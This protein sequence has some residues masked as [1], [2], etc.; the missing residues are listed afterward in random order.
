ME[1]GSRM[2][3]GK[4]LE[5]GAGNGTGE[6]AGGIKEVLRGLFKNKRAFGA[7]L[8]LGAG[9]VLA[10]GLWLAAGSPKEGDSWADEGTAG[11]N[12]TVNENVIYKEETA[13][14]PLPVGADEEELLSG[15]Y[16]AMADGSL[17]EAAE[18]LNSNEEMFK[19]LV[20]ETLGGD[21]Y[22]YYE[23]ASGVTGTENGPGAAAATGAEN[24]S[25]TAGAA[26][27]ENDSGTAGVTGA[28]NGSGAAAVT[29][30][31]NASG[32]ENRPVRKMEKLSE[33]GRS[34]GLVV[35]RYNTIFFG[36]FLNGVPEGQCIA[37]QAM[38]LNEPRYTYAAGI[39]S[40]GKMNGKGMTGFYYYADIPESGFVRTEK[41]GTYIDN[42]LDGAFTYRTENRDGEYLHWDMEADA[43]TTVLSDNW[44]YYD[45]RD[46]YML[47]SSED[48]A[49]AYVLKKDQTGAVLWNNLILWD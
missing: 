23:E 39:W 14:E 4:D 36:S 1:A 30:A 12:R 21:K 26:G 20:S 29:G 38:V 48:P 7:V 17:T 35:T 49:R 31:E 28:E 10:G 34:E 13:P 16:H 8:A 37:V 43:G 18:I 22:C 41:V 24:D 32:P 44:K 9:C 5:K 27:A 40:G 46:E 47:P 3:A 45:Y 19:T 25:G 2:T 15:L 6:D 33:T 11:R 42:L